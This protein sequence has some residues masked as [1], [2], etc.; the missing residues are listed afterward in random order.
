MAI[1][2]SVT[3]HI[4]AHE[5]YN[6]SWLPWLTRRIIQAVALIGLWGSL[7]AFTAAIVVIMSQFYSSA[8]SDLIELFKHA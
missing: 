5:P 6:Q 8:V 2:I 7:A 4:I 3:Q 1:K